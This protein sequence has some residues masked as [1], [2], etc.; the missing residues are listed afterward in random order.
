VCIGWLQRC[1]IDQNA[2]CEW[3]KLISLRLP[4]GYNHISFVLF[5]QPEEVNHWP[6]F[7]MFVATDSTPLHTRWTLGTRHCVPWPQIITSSI[8]PHAS[9]YIIKPRHVTSLDTSYCT[10]PQWF[11]VIVD[12]VFRPSGPAVANRWSADHWW[13]ARKFWWSVEKFGHCS[14]VIGAKYP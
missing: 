9:T 11:S 6:A 14:D 7:E 12:A 8:M 4:T 1:V 10:L 2:R 5:K 3:Y 13:S